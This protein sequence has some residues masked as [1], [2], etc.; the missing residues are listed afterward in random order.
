MKKINLLLI[1]IFTFSSSIAQTKLVRTEKLIACLKNKEFIK[2]FQI[3][4]ENNDTIFIYNNLRRFK[5]EI[6]EKTNCNKQIIVK[7]SSIKIN[8]NKF[9]PDCQ[10]KLVLYGFEEKNGIYKLRFLSICNNTHMIMELN[11]I[12]EVINYRQGIF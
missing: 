4:H 10:P 2:W 7:K 1:L 3:C 11:S 6:Q 5:N 12:N 8:P 9:I